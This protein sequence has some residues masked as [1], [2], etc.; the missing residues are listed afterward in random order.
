VLKAENLQRT[1]SFNIGVTETGIELNLGRRDEGHCEMLLQ[2]MR[3]WGYEVE[4]LT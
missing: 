1:G 3:S 2:T 4:R